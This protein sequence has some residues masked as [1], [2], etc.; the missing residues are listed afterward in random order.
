MRFAFSKP[1]SDK[2]NTATLFSFF[3]EAGY[4]ALQLKAGQ[5]ALR[6]GDV[7][8][9]RRGGEKH[10]ARN[11]GRETAVVLVAFNSPQRET[12]GE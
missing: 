3:R 1:T 4:D 9:I 12:E 8:V 5:T 2:E 6:P 7:I 10:Q 11:I